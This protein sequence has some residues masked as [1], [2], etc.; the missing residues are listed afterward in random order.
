MGRV[1][2]RKVAPGYTWRP[3]STPVGAPCVNKSY[4]PGGELTPIRVSVQK[5]GRGSVA[6]DTGSSH[7][8]SGWF[9]TL[10]ERVRPR[11]QPGPVPFLIYSRACDVYPMLVYKTRGKELLADSSAE[12]TGN[13]HAHLFLSF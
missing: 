13:L 9:W 4:S 10:P 5:F 7:R 2:L 12:A 6:S 8:A 3:A 1:F 11:R